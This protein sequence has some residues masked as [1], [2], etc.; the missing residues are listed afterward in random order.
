[1]VS[2]WNFNGYK[3]DQDAQS[4]VK[5]EFAQVIFDREV[6]LPP[7]IRNDHLESINDQRGPGTCIKSVDRNK[8]VIDPDC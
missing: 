3:I 5:K 4:K 8:N 6:F 2:V 1:M 7:Q